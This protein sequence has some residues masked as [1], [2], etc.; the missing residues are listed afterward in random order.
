MTPDEKAKYFRTE[1]DDMKKKRHEHRKGKTC[2]ACKGLDHFA[3]DIEC[4]NAPDY[5]GTRGG[6]KVE[7]ITLVSDFSD[8]E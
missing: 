3:N 7:H 1:T 8:D 4:P 6:P 2:A 5:L